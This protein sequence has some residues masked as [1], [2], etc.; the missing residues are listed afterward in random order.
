MAS[1]KQSSRLIILLISLFLVIIIF[2]AI[3]PFIVG[4]KLLSFF[5]TAVLV[6]GVF[7]V[8]EKKRQ[9]VSAAVLAI[10]ALLSSWLNHFNPHKTIFMFNYIFN[11]LFV[12]FVLAIVFLHVFKAKKI[13]A[14]TIIASICV[15]LLLSL[16]WTFLYILLELILPGSFNIAG[17]DAHYG[18]AREFISDKFSAL[19]YYSLVTITT[20]GYGDIVPT[21]PVARSLATLEA[22]FGQLYLTV[23][24]AR[25][26]GNHPRHHAAIDILVSQR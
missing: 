26:I 9:L 19:F 11:V 25:L 22:V 23:L 24:V 1:A 17:L 18:P 8:A 14:N 5:L 3:Q 4:V 10:C 20:L 2:P 7:A 12:G 16:F 15:Y 21:T 6:S 13:S